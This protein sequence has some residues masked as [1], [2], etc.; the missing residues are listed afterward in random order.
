MAVGYC[1]DCIHYDGIDWC[2][3]RREE[4]DEIVDKAFVLQN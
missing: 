3:L 2:K 4:H 1:K